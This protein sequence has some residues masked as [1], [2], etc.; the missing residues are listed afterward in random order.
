MSTRN[1][2][3]E[4]LNQYREDDKFF[5]S[6]RESSN[7][8]LS[9]NEDVNANREDINESTV[10]TFDGQMFPDFGHAVILAGGAGSGKSY[11]SSRKVAIDAKVFDVD[12]LKQLYIMAQKAGKISD[13]RDYD[14]SKPEDVS[15]L[16]MKVKEL[17]L[18]DKQEEAFYNSLSKDKLPNILYDITGD[19]PNKLEKLGAKLKSVGYK[20]TLVWVITNRQ[21]AMIQNLSRSR[22]VSQKVFH[23]I[24]NAIA[25]NVFP[26]LK[27]RA[28]DYDAAWIIFNSKEAASELPRSTKKD[29]DN[30]GIVKL[31]KQG[32]GFNIPNDIA[33]MIY[34]ILGPMEGDPEHPN[35]YMDF[36]DIKGN[37]ALIDN[38]RK[39]VD[40]LVKKTSTVKGAGKVQ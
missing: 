8:D 31:E 3:L 13:T 9:V 37:D 22:I 12:R 29:L 28:K 30:I 1:L 36:S 27:A 15:A 5:E 39:G 25:K 26:F 14:L 35:T 23:E 34:N 2:I 10:V 17:G 18:K 7:L 16:H 6:L 24:H 19:D 20:V 33:M 32:K 4:G 40:T 11:I 38:V 21:I